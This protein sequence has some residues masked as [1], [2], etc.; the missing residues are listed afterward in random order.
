M[1]KV[2]TIL[3]MIAAFGIG[4]AVAAAATTD[5]P[6]TNPGSPADDCSH[7][8]SDQGCKD[9]PQPDK[10][11]DCEDHGQARGNE[12][13]CGDVTEPTDTTDTTETTET[14]DTTETNTTGT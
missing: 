5:K 4:G 11:K 3:A 7:G 10:G 13:H 8:N 2:F 9:D 1:K 14:T 12:D 6:P